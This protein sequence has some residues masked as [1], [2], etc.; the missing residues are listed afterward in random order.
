MKELKGG[1]EYSMGVARTNPAVLLEG[2]T[3]DGTFMQPVR[4]KD[5]HVDDGK[6]VVV[7]VMVVVVVVARSE[8]WCR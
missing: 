5:R 3:L 8:Q 2:G 7:V 1:F 4:R 6:V